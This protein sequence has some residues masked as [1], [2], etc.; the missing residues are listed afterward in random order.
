M[1]LPGREAAKDCLGVARNTLSP[2]ARSIHNEPAPRPARGFRAWRGAMRL[3]TACALV[4]GLTFAATPAQAAAPRAGVRD[5][6]EDRLDRREDRRDRREDRRDRREDV[7]DARHDGGFLDRREDRFDR[8]EDWRDRR[9]DRRD[10]R[11]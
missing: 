9:E 8:R 6:L 11:R 7:R 10:R 2:S 4:M 1:Q 3:Q 5:R